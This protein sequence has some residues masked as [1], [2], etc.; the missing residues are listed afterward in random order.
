MPTIAPNPNTSD[1]VLR[2]SATTFAGA[3]DGATASSV[4]SAAATSLTAQVDNKSDATNYYVD[5]IVLPFDISALGGGATV[6]AATLDVN[7]TAIGGPA[8]ATYMDLV[9]VYPADYDSLA[10]GDWQHIV[11]NYTTQ[12]AARLSFS[13]T[14]VKTFTLNAAALVILQA[15]I[16]G[17]PSPGRVAFAIVMGNDQANSVSTPTNLALPAYTYVTIH[18]S[19]GGTPPVLTVTYTPGT[20]P[21]QISGSSSAAATGSLSL[22]VPAPAEITPAASNAAA[23]GSL[24]L[25]APPQV[26]FGSSSATATGSLDLTTTS[27]VG[28]RA[29]PGW[30]GMFVLDSSGASV[31][32]ISGGSTAVATGSL[33][34][35]VPSPRLISGSS[36]ATA[37]GTMTLTTGGSGSLS[38]ITHDTYTVAGT[39]GQTV[40]STSGQI[41]VAEISDTSP[42]PA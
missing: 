6:T 5:R 41:T 38:T 32:L 26:P 35:Q 36:N 34:L 16:A 20:T 37:T 40:T 2:K 23:S 8:G 42:I 29:A 24:S 3:H 31:P 18:S 39:G 17:S 1:G 13:T 10:V 12:L 9:A 19:T 22:T 14:G 33:S 11:S 25:T 21:A 30:L 4:I 15:R 7:V 28:A 27:A